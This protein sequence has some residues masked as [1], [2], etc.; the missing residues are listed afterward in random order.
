M[1]YR[2]TLTEQDVATIHFVGNSYC[3]SEALS[4]FDAGEHVLPEH[5]A[6]R[7]VDAFEAD[8][9]GGHSYF[10]MLDPRSPLADK[11]AKLIGDIT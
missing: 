2:L 6:W 4:R 5:V 1:T 9:E 3:W 7:L 10:P 11:L 8:T